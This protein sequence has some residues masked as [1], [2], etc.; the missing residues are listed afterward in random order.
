MLFGKDSAA[1]YEEGPIRQF[2]EF[3]DGEVVIPAEDGKPE[4]SNFVVVTPQD[5]HSHWYTIGK[6]SVSGEFFCLCCMCTQENKSKSYPKFLC[7]VTISD[8][9]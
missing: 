4:L 2:F 3:F 6:G 5:M 9:S 8:L 7:G 1:A